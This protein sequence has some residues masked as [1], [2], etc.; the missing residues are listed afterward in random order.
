VT[1]AWRFKAN[2]GNRTRQQCSS[3]LL[4]KPKLK[5]QAGRCSDGWSDGACIAHLVL[6]SAAATCGVLQGG[7]LRQQPLY[8]LC[9]H[10]R[11]NRQLPVLLAWAH[12]LHRV[13]CLTC[14]PQ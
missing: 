8:M 6:H 14:Q 3:V 1:R 12:C 7:M 2:V 5:C 10:A 4:S 9:I 13:L 11:P